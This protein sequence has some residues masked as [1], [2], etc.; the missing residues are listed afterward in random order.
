MVR[1]ARRLPRAVWRRSER[2]VNR[3]LDVLESTR[4]GDTGI[5][6]EHPPLFIIG[7]PRSGSTLL[8]Q[9]L[10]QSFDVAYLSN[11]HC[12]VYGAPALVERLTHRRIAPPVS[13]ESAFG[14][15]RGARAPSECGEYWYRFFRRF[16]Q[17]VP[18]QDAERSKLRRLRASV[19][20]LGRAGGR[21]IAF[22]NLL[23]SL[24]LAPIGAALPEALFIV[25][26]RNL[27][28]NATSLL[29]ARRQI[30]GDY[31]RWWSAEPPEIERL[32][33]LPAHEQ[34]V[35]QVRTIEAL[36]DRDRERL[37]GDR[38][39]EVRYEELC[40]DPRATMASIH[41]FAG[42]RGVSLKQR[43]VVPQ[44]FERRGTPIDEAVG[45]RLDAYIRS[46]PTA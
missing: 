14:G 40:D 19:R 28:D 24:R 43:G 36:I 42:R 13:Y 38:F 31:S 45:E 2:A 5:P 8:Y 18:L 26:R 39:L 35:E 7:A 3:V 1:G 10:V 37:G 17:Y 4:G 30:H 21:P 11:L 32:R 23:C 41:E 6:L 34:V 27:V 46:A 9:V 22:K 12:R 20:A 29:A 15:T 25:V 16:P 33:E 44:R